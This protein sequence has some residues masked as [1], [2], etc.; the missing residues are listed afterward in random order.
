MI[1]VECLSRECEH[2]NAPPQLTE[3]HAAILRLLA[4]GKTN[5]EIA[6]QRGTTEGTI[7]VYLS[8][9]IFKRLGVK[10]RLQAALWARDHAELLAAL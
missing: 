9:A 2:V 6:A 1:C 4:E 10:T 5:R 7:K 8:R 3:I